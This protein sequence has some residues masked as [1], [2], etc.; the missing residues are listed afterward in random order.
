MKIFAAALL[1]A[2]TVLSR[3][4]S[5]TS[6]RFTGTEVMNLEDRE[7]LTTATTNTIDRVNEE[8]AAERHVAFSSVRLE[9]GNIV[10]RVTTGRQEQSFSSARQTGKIAESMEPT[11]TASMIKA[12]QA[13]TGVTFNSARIQG[14]FE[15]IEIERNWYTDVQDAIDEENWAVM[16]ATLCTFFAAAIIA[17]I[18]GLLIGRCCC[19]KEDKEADSDSQAVA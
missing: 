3:D 9:G 2:T 4:L 19:Q 12:R 6:R 8:S 7:T 18:V 11:Y 15:D 17:L 16:T 10:N 5:F 13:H 14:K 1:L